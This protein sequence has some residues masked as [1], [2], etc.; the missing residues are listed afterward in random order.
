MTVPDFRTLD[1]LFT[2]APT[3]RPTEFSTEFY[4]RVI[5]GTDFWRVVIGSH[6]DLVLEGKGVAVTRLH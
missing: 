1:T 4:T 3:L 5:D 6:I 2:S